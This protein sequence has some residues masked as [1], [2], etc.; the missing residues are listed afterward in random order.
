MTKKHLAIPLACVTALWTFPATAQVE[1][2]GYVST[3]YRARTRGAHALTWNENRLDLRLEGSVSE[4]AA[5]KGE[6]WLR[7]FGFPT[8][9]RL[10]HLQQRD[11]S[12]TLPWAVDLRE[13]Y[14]EIYG[15][16]LPQ[17]DVRLGKQRIA[18][19][20]ADK[21]NPTDNLNPKDFE[22]PLDFGRKLPVN[23]L[24]I[25]GY[26]GDWSIEL[27]YVPVFTPAVLPP[28]DWSFGALPGAASLPQSGGVQ[29]VSDVVLP[30]R[31]L[32][33]GASVGIKLSGNVAG[34]DVSASYAFV[35]DDLPI[36]SRI[37]T[38][39]G[40]AG[41]ESIHT[42]L[43]FPRLHVFGADL[44][45]ELLG[46]GIWA[47]AAAFLPDEAVYQYQTSEILQ[48][49]NRITYI[50]PPKLLL[51]REVYTKWVV[52]GDYTFRNGWYV[53]GQF[54]HGFYGE[55]GRD[56]LQDYLVLA[57]E[58]KL[59]HETV[60]LRFAVAAQARELRHPSR[61]YTWIALPEL[62]YYPSDN[63]ELQLGGYAIR[64]R[65]QTTLSGFAGND[66][67]FVKVKVSF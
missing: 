9:T 15:F 39:V 59:W 54:V 37:Q 40:Q 61:D 11:R 12:H 47:E 56:G 44:A 35:R 16:L 50:L 31:T 62:S 67:V 46:A 55:R 10:E 4:K 7:S 18:W 58:K 8:A 36:P 63:V 28:P 27:D 6:L 42:W 41:V 3:D 29:V 64:S 34:Y 48:A 32:R 30:E 52:G 33:D 24:Q 65:G 14:L 66:E 51:E 38:V 26:L 20:T 2:N 1:L 49:G 53:N 5:F 60:K 25:T 57:A 13:A 23:A 17:V 43:S 22:D 21:I 45:G 19:G